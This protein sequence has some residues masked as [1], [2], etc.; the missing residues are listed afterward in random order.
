MHWCAVGYDEVAP[1]KVHAQQVRPTTTTTTTIIF[2]FH[3]ALALAN[4]K[5][6][7]LDFFNVGVLWGTSFDERLYQCR[8][9]ECGGTD[10]KVRKC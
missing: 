8:T 1:F 6:A 2:H 7:Q 5:S 3:S 4:A 10:Q 9:R